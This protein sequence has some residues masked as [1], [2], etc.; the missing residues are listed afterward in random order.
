MAWDVTE[1]EDP[2]ISDDLV[3]RACMRERL[4]RGRKKRGV[5]HAYNGN[6]MRAVTLEIQ[7]EE[8]VVL[9]SFSRQGVCSDN[10]YSGSLFRTA[11]YW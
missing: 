9:R 8:L 6:A 7:L 3:R 4:R 10:P 5:Q 2:A 11:K 1:R